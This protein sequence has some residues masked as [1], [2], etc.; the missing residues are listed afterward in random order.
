MLYNSEKVKTP[1]Y[2][3]ELARKQRLELTVSE[4]ILWEELKNRQLQDFRFRCQHP[5]YRYILDFY[6][7]ETQLAVEIDGDIHKNRIEYDQYRDEFLE[8]LGIITLRFSVDDV[9]SKI[10]DVTNKILQASIERK[11]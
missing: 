6:C 3:V 9:M 1:R 5:V 2:V 11:A 10:E 8:S 4:E 7:H